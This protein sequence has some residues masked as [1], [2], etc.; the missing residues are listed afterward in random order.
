[1][2][3]VPVSGSDLFK[4]RKT[5]TFNGTTIGAVA[6]LSIFDIQGVVLIDRII[7]VCTADLVSGG[8]STIGL[9]VNGNGQFFI[10][11]TSY[12]NLDN[13]SIWLS[14]TNYSTVG[15]EL[16]NGVKDHITRQDIILD[17]LVAA[18][19]AGSLDVTVFWRPVTADGLV[20][21]L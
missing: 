12:A 13:G 4:A 21:P 9:G 17:I 14:D 19:T 20:L 7:P 1:M 8:A 16:T 10:A 15:G 5:I 6:P 3:R 2:N 11:P 18:I